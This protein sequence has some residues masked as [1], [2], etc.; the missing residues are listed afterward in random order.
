MSDNVAIDEAEPEVL[1]DGGTH[2]DEHMGVEMTLR[3]FHWLVDGYGS[4]PRITSIVNTREVWI[5]FIVNPD[6]VEYDIS[7]GHF[8]FWRQNRQPTPATCASHR[9]FNRNPWGVT[10][11]PTRGHHIGAGGVLLP[12]IGCAT[13]SPAASSTAGSRSGRRSRSTRPA[14]WSCGRTATP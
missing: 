8:H 6:G 9:S 3:I 13:S 14:A 5:V 4:D 10:R 11:A 7:G 12:R 1:F 2:S